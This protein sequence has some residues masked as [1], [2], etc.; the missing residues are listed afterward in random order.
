MTL[1]TFFSQIQLNY[2]YYINIYKYYSVSFLY[3]RT[4]TSDNDCPKFQI[5]KYNPKMSLFT[6]NLFNSQNVVN[7]YFVSKSSLVIPHYKFF[8]S[9]IVRDVK[10]FIKSKIFLSRILY[11]PIKFLT[12]N[13]VIKNTRTNFFVF[14]YRKIYNLKQILFRKL[15]KNSISKSIYKSNRLTK[16]EYAF[17]ASYSFSM[18]ENKLNGHLILQKVTKN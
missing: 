10:F 3:N 16:L 1:S 7:H 8:L 12:F 15:N 13:L 4:S 9:K 5:E 2:F 17:K 6:T 11:N 18:F 14:L